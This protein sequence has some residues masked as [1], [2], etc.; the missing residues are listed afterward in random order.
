MKIIFLTR[1]A[2][3]DLDDL[4]ADD[5]TMIENAL[6]AYAIKGAGDIKQL[7][8]RAG[9]RMRIG[10]YRILFDEDRL[11]ILAFYIGRRATTTYRKN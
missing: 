10:S 4:P 9:Y 5:R 1:S 3:K 11:T 2:A 7:S 6:S 8:G